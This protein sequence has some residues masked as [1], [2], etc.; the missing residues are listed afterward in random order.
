MRYRP[1]S[2]F[3][4]Y[5]KEVIGQTEVMLNELQP[6]TEYVIS[7]YSIYENKQSIPNVVRIT[8]EAP[9]IG[10]QICFNYAK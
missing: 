2:S 8:T 10:E 7:V 3:D 4:D 9:Q 5:T 6:N 1:A